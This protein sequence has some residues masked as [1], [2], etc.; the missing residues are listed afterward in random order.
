M[1]KTLQLGQA[2]NVTPSD[3]KPVEEIKKKGA[4]ELAIE[5]IKK[6]PDRNSALCLNPISYEKPV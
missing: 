4:A 2:I 3:T 1:A 6:G 5:G